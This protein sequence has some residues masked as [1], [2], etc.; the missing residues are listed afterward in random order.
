MRVKCSIVRSLG[1]LHELSKVKEVGYEPSEK[2][3]CG[4]GAKD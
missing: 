2:N 3:G 1:G 4:E